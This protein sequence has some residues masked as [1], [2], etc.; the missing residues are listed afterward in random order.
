MAQSI[1]TVPNPNFGVAPLS[2][3]AN[4]IV[5]RRKVK[6]P[7]TNPTTVSGIRASGNAVQSYIYFDIADNECFINLANL[8][9]VTEFVFKGWDDTP[10][11]IGFD[12]SIQSMIASFSVGSS[13]GLKIEEITNYSLYASLL[14]TI[15]E[16][17]DEKDWSQQHY[18]VWNKQSTGAYRG[19]YIPMD[20]TQGEDDRVLFPGK[21]YRIHM[22][23][24]HSSL[25]KKAAYLPLFI[26]R[27]GIRIQFNFESVYRC[28]YV[29]RALNFESRSL[30]PMHS[31][32]VANRAAA[33]ILYP[34]EISFFFTKGCSDYAT[35]TDVAP[36]PAYDAATQISTSLNTYVPPRQFKDVG[37][38]TTETPAYMF[39]SNMESY[40]S[41]FIAAEALTGITEL[42]KAPF[43]TLCIPVKLYRKITATTPGQGI[44]GDKILFWSGVLVRLTPSVQI[45]N[46]ANNG[47]KQN[48]FS[49]T[50]GSNAYRSLMGDRSLP[51]FAPDMTVEVPSL[52]AVDALLSRLLP[53]NN[54]DFA[55]SAAVTVANSNAAT[56]KQ[57]IGFHMISNDIQNG[58]ITP[59]GRTQ[60]PQQIWTSVNAAGSSDNYFLEIFPKDGYVFPNCNFTKPPIPLSGSWLH[61]TAA[62]MYHNGKTSANWSYSLDRS[63]LILDLVKPAADDFAKVQA[64]FTSPTGIPYALD[65]ILYRKTSFNVSGGVSQVGVNISVRSLRSILLCLQD[66]SMTLE[67]ATSDSRYCTPLLTSFLRCGLS[68]A[69][70]VV[71]GQVYPIYPMMLR[72][73]LSTTDEQNPAQLIELKSMLG[74]MAPKGMNTA[75]TLESCKSGHRLYTAWGDMGISDADLLAIQNQA[76]NI[77]VGASVTDAS[78]FII[79]F[80]LKKD[81]I[82]SFVTGIDTS[83]AGAVHVNLYFNDTTNRSWPSTRRVDCHTFFVCDAIF[84]AQNDGNLVRY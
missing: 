13:Q 37:N 23:V 44:L 77:P 80:S 78:N 41:V 4:T 10:V 64:A 65:R 61:P 81:D 35:R 63:E 39:P 34:S 30:I 27:N 20:H 15:T 49:A 31:G 33:G 52:V 6:I 1:S 5:Q 28:M 45:V 74:N 68:Q 69:E 55:G 42:T 79:G 40:Q 62:L 8:V 7:M 43:G 24:C 59:F 66:E 51:T 18:S 29:P 11:R 76:G 58:V 72:G 73:Q 56:T 25:I 53:A 47:T 19:Q 32:I 22:Q 50:V 17:P 12:P 83:Q 57:F 38:D 46:I 48:L 67:P 36:S 82:Q 3:I 2:T 70:V 60:T 84:T 26:F 21:K 14:E 16:S 9:F 71:G 75:V 54:A